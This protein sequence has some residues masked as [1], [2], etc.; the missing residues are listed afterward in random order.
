MVLVRAAVADDEPALGALNRA[1]WS[2]DVSPGQRPPDDE[3]FFKARLRPEDVLVA[4]QDGVLVGFAIV[5][6]ASAMPTHGHVR[7]LN[8]LS[9]DPAAQ[10]AGIGRL[11]VD[12]AAAWA[13]E[14]GARKLTLRVLDGNTRARRLYLGAGF[15]VEGV[16]VAEYLVA[17][18]SV[19]DVLMALHLD[20]GSASG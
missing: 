18:R 16:L 9:V 14:L 11:L 8:G 4:E 5:T 7:V 17:G 15:V 1:T 12:A 10:G 19:D 6:P 3:G 20:G 13:R 2:P